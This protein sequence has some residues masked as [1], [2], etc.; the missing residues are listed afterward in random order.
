MALFFS[1]KSVELMIKRHGTPLTIER[2]VRGQ[3]DTKTGTMTTEEIESVEVVGF[4][5]ISRL[6]EIQ[7]TAV[8]V[9]DR[10]VMLLPYD[11]HG[12]PY[13]V[14]TNDVLIDPVTNKRLAISRVQEYRSG[15]ELLANVL[16]LE[17]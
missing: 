6:D 5:S 8:P 7:F 4:I 16:L 3:Y 1:N 9:G 17:E 15:G 12:Y 13:E 2:P 14:S 10:R 11:T